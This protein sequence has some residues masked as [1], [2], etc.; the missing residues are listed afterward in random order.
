MS[1]CGWLG[2]LIVLFVWSGTV[3]A[4]P[5]AAPATPAKG[6]VI[7]VVGGV[8]GLEN[9][10]GSLQMA[11]K[12]EKLDLEVRAFQWTHGKGHILKDL[13]D[14]RHHTHKIAELVEELRALK[15][16]Q[17]DRPLYLVGRSGGSGLALAAADLLEPATLER[18][19]LLSPAVS[20]TFDLRGA[21]RATR[22]EIVSFNSDLDV[23]V[24][25]WGT[26]QFGTVDRL[27]CS[28]AG[29]SGFSK[30]TDPDAETQELYRRLIQVRWTPAMLLEGH[31]GGHL[32]TTLPTFLAREVVP[33]LKPS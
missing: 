23:V 31:T 22:H 4:E 13:Q 27:Y 2:K 19:I 25:G 28:S 6:G 3:L 32:G 21:L 8:G 17:P 26:W 20:P 14:S 10:H 11:L 16:E 15:A 1:R 9:L 30:P 5:E 29:R 24:L 12:W 18:I 33:W 7:V